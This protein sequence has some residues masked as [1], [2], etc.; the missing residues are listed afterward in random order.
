MIAILDIQF[1]QVSLHDVAN[2]DAETLQ[3]S[4]ITF[5]VSC[6]TP[7][8]KSI[9]VLGTA[10]FDMSALQLSKYL[11]VTERLV[12]YMKQHSP[13]I[14]GSLKV[15]IKLGC[16]KLY[17]GKE[18]VGMFSTDLVKCFCNVVTVILQKHWR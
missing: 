6:R 7:K 16:G 12:L 1:K 3:K 15:T 14:L 5:T 4:H 2:L 17:F 11:T 9:N 10:T 13:V 8:Q 18:F